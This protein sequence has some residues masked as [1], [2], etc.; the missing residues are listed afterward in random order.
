MDETSK[1]HL[2]NLLH[3]FDTGFLISRSHGSDGEQEHARPMAV[4]AI[5][6]ADTI[7][8]VTGE[9]TPKVWEIQADARVAVTFQSARRFVALSGQAQLVADRAK[10]AQ[11]WKPAWKVWFPNGKE[12][13]DLRLV[14]VTVTDAEFWDEAGM[15]GIKYVIGA[16]R[17]LVAGKRPE[18]SFDQDDQHGRVKS[19][20]SAAAPSRH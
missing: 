11:L 13:P 9:S 18:S 15:K 6:G 17:A 5:E 7:W 16:A 14:R 2:S 20:E 1:Q 4:A 10:I 19:P 8:F 3:S 12:D